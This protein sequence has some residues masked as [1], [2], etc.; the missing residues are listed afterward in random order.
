MTSNMI[1]R[2]GYCCPIVFGQ[3]KTHLL[4]VSALSPCYFRLTTLENVE[5]A[6]IIMKTSPH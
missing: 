2:D 3:E 4:F 1:P 6:E 5:R